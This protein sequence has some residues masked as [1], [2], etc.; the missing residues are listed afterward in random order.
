MADL[1]AI[2]ASYGLPDGMLSA[3][4][5]VESGGN[6]KAVSPKGAMGP[7]Q[8][9]APTAAEM[10]VTNPF[11]EDQ[12]APAAAQLLAQNYQ[13]FGNWN[14]ALAAYNAG[15]AAVAK[16]GGVPNYPETQAYVQKVNAAMPIDT[17]KVQWDDEQQP[18][19]A[20][21]PA[22]PDPSSVKWDDEQP[23]APSAAP[24]MSDQIMRQLGLTARDVG[25]GVAAGLGTLANGVNGAINMAGSAIGHN[26]GLQDVDTLL[27]KQIDKVTPQPQGALEQGVNAAA[28]ALANPLNAVAGPVAAGGGIARGALAGAVGAGIQPVHAGDTLG[29]YAQNMAAGAATGGAL[30][31]VGKILKG[32][33]FSPAAQSLIDQGV[34]PTPGQALGG[35]AKS[36][37]ERATSIPGLGD[38][39]KLA[40]R[41]AVQDMNRAAYQQ[42]LD[43]I[44]GTAPTKVGPE[45]IQ[46]VKAQIQAKY[47]ALLPQLTWKM[48]PQFVQD[49][50]GV[51]QTV[52]TLPVDLQNEYSNQLQRN[53]FSQIN[54]G[55]MSG[56]TF[57]DV[58]SQI[59]QEAKGFTSSNDPFQRRLGQ[60]LYDT[61]NAM[62]GAL[63]RANPQAA[64]LPPINQAWQNYAVLR[65]AA[66]RVNN[67]ETPIMPGQL[68]AAVKAGDK[69]VGKGNFGVNRT[70]PMQQLSDPAM[71]V[72]GSQYPDSG[73]AGR[74]LLAA[75][76]GGGGTALAHPAAIPLGAA[77][78]GYGTPGG[79]QA[80]LSLLASRPDLLRQMGI[81]AQSLAPQ[82]GA[83]AGAILNKAQP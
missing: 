11:D 31:T 12:A 62:R 48:D 15:P 8:F 46:Q 51:S 20:A 32:A 83:A 16:A 13:R 50:A 71:Q 79:R 67:P 37:E 3:V 69:S 55:Q 27:D 14:H 56:T 45:A 25:H 78:A 60:S 77:M 26:P 58:E 17:S 42:V 57:K 80:M 9:M 40:Q 4:K 75:L 59:G 41:S 65:N 5:Q 38:T 35:V 7:F 63:A 72:L 52:K 70:A 21:P 68:Q 28:S 22:G 10:G 33:T 24:S 54:Q 29:N 66:A 30:G 23:A 81:G 53:L 73:T 64:E 19:Q 6:A 43:P 47:N 76:L 2:E 82:A 61:Q 36:L 44:G 39:I 74:Y 34:T 49:M 1:G 18:A